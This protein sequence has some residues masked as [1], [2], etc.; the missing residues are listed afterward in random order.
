MTQRLA[1][2]VAL[3][4]VVIGILR[5]SPDAAA[6]LT[7]G[8]TQRLTVYSGAMTISPQRHC[9]VDIGTLCS[10]DA[11]CPVNQ[12]CVGTMEIGAA[13]VDITADQDIK[14]L[15]SVQPGQP[16]AQSTYFSGTPGTNVQNLTVSGDVDI[17]TAGKAVC[18]QG[19][20][21]TSWNR[22]LENWTERS[23]GT[24]SFLQPTVITRGVSIGALTGNS[25]DMYSAGTAVSAQGLTAANHAGMAAYFHGSVQS[26]GTLTVW[27]SMTGSGPGTVWNAGND[28]QGSGL[29]AHM[30]DG[31]PATM[32]HGFACDA[33]VCVC[34]KGTPTHHSSIDMTATR[35][36]P[37]FAGPTIP[38]QPW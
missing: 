19:V 20:C 17:M 38:S 1:I 26:V 30:L 27:G 5:Y 36:I 34:F 10:T 15:P 32:R 37:L 25:A 22:N 18:M 23:T 21:K 9:S 28:G 3:C 29:N 33:T 13:G 24:Y 6:V 31:V 14:L 7:T 4:L 35:C 11:S 8:A 2:F 16:P 12:R